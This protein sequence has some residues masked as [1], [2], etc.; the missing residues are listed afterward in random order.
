VLPSNLLALPDGRLGVVDFGDCVVLEDGE[1]QELARLLDATARRDE[2]AALHTLD[3]L[4]AINPDVDRRALIARLRWV[5]QEKGDLWSADPLHQVPHLF[6][7]LATSGITV[8]VP[9]L[10]LSENL[11][12]VEATARQLNA[13]LELGPHLEA[14]C[15]TRGARSN[16][17]Y[18]PP[19]APSEVAAAAIP[20][21]ERKP[22]S[23][24]DVPAAL[25]RITKAMSS[26]ESNTLASLAPLGIFI[27][28]NSTFGVIPAI[29]AATASTLGLSLY[30]RYRGREGGTAAKVATVLIFVQATL[31]LALRSGKAFLGPLLIFP[32]LVTA[33]LFVS[34]VVGRPIFGLMAN[35]V[36]PQAPAVRNSPELRRAYTI[37]TG[38]AASLHL[39]MVVGL[40]WMFVALSTNQ[41]AALHV[42]VQQVQLPITLLILLYVKRVV[43]RAPEIEQRIVARAG[44]L[45]LPSA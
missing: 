29:L 5:V 12:H 42:L 32:A 20:T 3:R 14:I 34:I 21:L 1:R 4:G 9:L 7:A 24:R 22:P 19:L 43:N 26:G 6:L 16:D 44:G 23:F 17:P 8:P 18:G 37:T 28:T 30:R 38:V 15:K 45:S 10:R 40:L 27:V 25:G 31:G 41:F 2:R 35:F 33:I 13:G 36:W 39:L 11:L